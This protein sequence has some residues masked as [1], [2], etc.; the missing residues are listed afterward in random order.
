[1]L[2][3]LIFNDASSSET[4]RWLINVEQFMVWELA[5][6]TEV[7]EKNPPQYHFVR[8]KSHKVVNAIYP[9]FIV[10]Q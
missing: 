2:I 1:M 6:E 8:H 3:S 7:L 5:G 10:Q 4:I 9:Q